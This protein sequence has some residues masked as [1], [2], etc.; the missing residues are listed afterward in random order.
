MS[1]HSNPG[2]TAP[3]E[4]P[5]LTTRDYLAIDRTHL[6]NERTMLAFLRTALYM[7]VTGL[8]IIN[9]YP[10]TPISFVSACILFGIGGLIMTLGIVHYFVMKS[11]IRK[12]YK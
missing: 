10:D 8:A 4:V 11:K 5:E 6:A 7:I 12:H 3:Q 2:S 9:F 1:N